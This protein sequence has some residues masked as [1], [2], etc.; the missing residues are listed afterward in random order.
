M[1]RFV[2]GLLKRQ[3]G[4]SMLLAGIVSSNFDGLD[5]RLDAERLKQTNDLGAYRQVNP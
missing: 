2:T 1:A 4:L 5:R 3:A